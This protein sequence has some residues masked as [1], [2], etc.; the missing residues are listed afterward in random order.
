MSRPASVLFISNHGDIVGG[1]EISLLQ[2]MGALDRSQWKPLLV[3]PHE[4]AVAK[5]AR[6][7]DIS[8]FVVPL[9]A[10]SGTSMA[11]L[12]SIRGLWR[13]MRQV[14]A[15]LVHAN[16]SRAM[17]YGGLAAKL[18]YCPA[19]WHVRVADSDGWLDWALYQLSSKII[20][21]SGAVRQRFAWGS[22]D[23]VRCIHNGVDTERFAPRAASPECRAA[24]GLADRDR[25]VVS[26][27]RFV[28][29]KGYEEL[30]H[31]A[32]LLHQRDA[33]IHWILVGDGELRPDMMRQSKELGLDRHVHF[34]GWQA[35]IR[36]VLAL[37]DLFVLPSRGEH[38]G[39]VLIEAMA[40]GKA[41]VAT[42]AGGVPE[43]V[44]HGETGWLVKPGQPERL[45]EA[46][47]ELLDNGER[48]VQFG[49]A[50]RRVVESRFSLQRH[51][52]HVESLYRNLTGVCC[53]S[54]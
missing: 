19:V 1:G 9:P 26:V 28:A 35:D 20:V 47:G 25:V 23:R 22:D 39:R 16:G 54:V 33:G 41:V 32:A 6:N 49:A 3:V 17:I 11:S 18:A 13:L 48:I 50:G 44:R 38:F 46:V 8:T 21:N 10:V 51:V 24:M 40:M 15:Q 5:E 30:L 12:S 45:A 42:D 43:I 37:A 2:L 7:S 4:G 14:E 52:Q 53:G 29:Y 31:A 27:G 34:T 36:E